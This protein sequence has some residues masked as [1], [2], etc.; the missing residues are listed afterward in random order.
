LARTPTAGKLTVRVVLRKAV[1]FHLTD[2]GLWWE[3]SDRERCGLTIAGKLPE[4]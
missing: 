2:T 1:T 4:I 3:I